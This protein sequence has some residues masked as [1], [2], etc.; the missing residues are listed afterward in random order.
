M[1]LLCP[2][3]SLKGGMTTWFGPPQYQIYFFNVNKNPDVPRHK[4]LSVERNSTTDVYNLNIVNL[5]RFEDTGTYMC[6]VNAV[7]VSQEKTIN[8]AFYGKFIF[9]SNVK[10]NIRGILLI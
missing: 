6:Q 2:F 3:S 5:N 8:L 9:F 4:R 7:N 10:L 1:T